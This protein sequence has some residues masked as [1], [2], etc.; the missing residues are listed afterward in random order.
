MS[1]A[2]LYIPRALEPTIMRLINQYPVITLVGPRQSGKTTLARHLFSDWEYVNLEDP[3]T[4]IFATED[5][6]GFFARYPDRLIIDEAQHVPE[7]LSKIQVLVDQRG[8]RAG[9]FILTGSQEIHIH[10][11]LSQSLAGR[12]AIVTVMPLSLSELSQGDARYS[13][14]EQLIRGFM[15]RLYQEP[16]LIATEYW[17]NYVATYVQRDVK[18]IIA[19]QDELQFRTFLTLLAGRVGGLLNHTR[20]ANDLGV[21]QKTVQRWVSLLVSSHIVFLLPAWAPSRTSAIVKTPKLYFCDP[22]LA[23]YLLGIEEETQMMRDPLRGNL[24]ENMVVIEAMKTALNAYRQPV[25]SFF[26][27]SS[28]LEVD[29]LISR[30]RQVTGYEIKSGETFTKDQMANLLQ[31]E[32]RYSEYLHPLHKGGLIYAGSDEQIFLEHTVTPYQRAGALFGP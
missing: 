20:L 1:V 12:V 16:D 13:R 11:M 32:K 17:S 19:I 15:P 27:N 10:G 2:N 23:S 26:R 3:Q 31:F 14:D 9:Q 18:Q 25:L 21:A 8:Q 7:L 22:G 29:L 6:N 24:F 5:I 4:R 30:Q 28:G